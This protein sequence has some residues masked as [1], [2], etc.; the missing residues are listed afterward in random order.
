MK[1]VA[2]K[3]FVKIHQILFFQKMLFFHQFSTRVCF[4]P[5]PPPS[6]R[7]RFEIILSWAQ[8]FIFI[9]IHW[10]TFIIKYSTCSPHFSI[11][12]SIHFYESIFPPMFSSLMGLNVEQQKIFKHLPSLKRPK[13]LDMPG[14][15]KKMNRKFDCDF[16]R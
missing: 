13:A 5:P 4:K 9:S 10:H 7:R 11:H 2:E 8:K 15:L 12:Y 14:G 3:F 1:N 16:C 6:T